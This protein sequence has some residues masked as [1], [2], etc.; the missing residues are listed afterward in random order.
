[1]IKK[2]CLTLAVITA[3]SLSV[4]SAQQVGKVTS[5]GIGYLEYL[6]KGYSS[7][8]NK[9][10]LVISL[11]GI[12]EKG[13]SSTDPKL[14]LASL[15]LVDNVGL[16]K[17]VLYGAQYPFIL[18]SPQLKSQYATW[19]P[20]Y[21]IEVLNYVKKYL[22]VDERRVY[23]T[24]LSLGGL[25]VW[26]TAGDYPTVFAA[27]A[28]VCAAG[29][30]IS[31]AS[32]IAAA[33]VAVWGFHGG[34]DPIVSY[35]VTTSMVNA[36]NSSPTKP[37][38]LAK[39]TIF[40][41]MNHSIWDKTYN[42]TNVLEWMLGFSRGSVSYTPP[43]SEVTPEITTNK[44]PVVSAGHDLTII[45]PTNSL[46]IQGTAQD[47]DGKIISVNW[48]QYYG[49]P[50]SLSETTSL[51]FRAYN[52]KEGIYKFRLTVKDNSGAT[53]YDNMLVSVKQ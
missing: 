32:A 28:P 49:V 45:L 10:P 5:S 34:S 24:G 36:I 22:R 46:Y 4:V 25:G 48:T 1:M 11:H 29:N 18:I 37:N 16:P 19:P 30:A 9:Y 41:G 50:A 47:P 12:K 43:P 53:Q 51:K 52:L 15:P 26:K 40:P 7:N 6:P 2:F 17:Y 23:L 27:I 21:I 35:T 14:V 38:P 44:P 13:T 8:S 33:N 20:A 31:K 42:E 39:A 3:A